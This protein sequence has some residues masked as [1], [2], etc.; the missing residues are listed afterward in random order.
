MSLRNKIILPVFCIAM[1]WLLVDLF[2]ARRDVSVLL[3]ETVETTGV[4]HLWGA[5]DGFGLNANGAIFAVLDLSDSAAQSIADGGILWLN[6]QPG[7]RITP[8]W[9]PTP[10]PRTHFWMGRPDSTA[11][12]WPNPTILAVR[13]EY[14]AGPHIPRDP[15][16]ALDAALNAQG[17]FYAVG[18]GRLVAV[19]V[20]ATRRAF[21]FYAG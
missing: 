6:A 1:A 7:G 18:P 11:G 10:V 5:K 19:V 14:G 16:I 4:S 9:Q 12:P 13:E 20:P 15:Q 8:D 21:V 3:P 2:A 17:S